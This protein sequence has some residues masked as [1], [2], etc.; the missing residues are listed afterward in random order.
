MKQ[1]IVRPLM[2]EKATQMTNAKVYS[3]VVHPDANKHAVKVTVESMYKVKVASVRISIRKGKEKRVGRKMQTVS[4]PDLKIAFV[5]VKE[6]TIDIF[7]K[8]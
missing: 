5:T 1:S 3:F 4:K 6:G 7:P 8:A 2:T